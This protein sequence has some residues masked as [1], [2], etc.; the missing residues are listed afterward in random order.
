MQSADMALLQHLPINSPD[1]TCDILVC[2]GGFAGWAAA[3]HASNLGARVVLV[4]PKDFFE[5]TPSSPRCL[6]DPSTFP[7]AVRSHVSLARNSSINVVRGTITDLEPRQAL[8]VTSPLDTSAA[9]APPSR[10]SFTHCIWAAGASYTPPIKSS[11]PTSAA[12]LA[13]LESWNSRLRLTPAISVIGGGFVGIELAAELSTLSPR[14]KINLF[15]PRILP[16]L[17]PRASHYAEEF[18]RAHG[19]DILRRRL[20]ATDTAAVSGIVFDCTGSLPSPSAAPLHRLASRKGARAFFGRSKRVRVR[21]TLQ[22][23]GVDSVFVAGDAGETGDEVARGCEKTG[24]A[25]LEAGTLAARNAM[26]LRSG[27]GLGQFPEDAFGGEFPSM[28]IVSLGKWDGVMCLGPVVVTGRLAAVA[29]VA[30]EFMTV[31]RMGGGCLGRLFGGVERGFYSVTRG[32]GRIW[33]WR[34]QIGGGL[35]RQGA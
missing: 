9:P 28:F 13:D 17:P 21:P 33:G 4:D 31:R 29:K 24:Y 11:S 3:R 23:V 34:R 25:A 27:G 7:R 2:G 10:I 22:L 18:L 16:R 32:L 30:V 14:P 8:A 12:R 6:V 1:L 5:F 15:S 19:V 20:S 26:A 35:G